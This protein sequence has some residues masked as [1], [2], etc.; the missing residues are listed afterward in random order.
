MSE[1]LFSAIRPKRALED[2]RMSEDENW[3]EFGLSTK[4]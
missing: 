3:Q 2:E 1:E 4:R